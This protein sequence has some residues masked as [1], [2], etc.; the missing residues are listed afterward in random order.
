MSFDLVQIIVWLVFGAIIGAIAGRI[1]NRGKGGFGL[2]GNII[3]GIVGALLGGFLLDLTGLS[4]IPESVF[5]MNVVG[6]TITLDGIIASI[7]G[8]LLFVILLR[9][10]RK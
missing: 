5:S 6:T 10:V 4:L 8:A 1:L 7:V 9:F 3:V 2:V